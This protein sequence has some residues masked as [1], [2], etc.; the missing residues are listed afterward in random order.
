M[1]SDGYENFP[2][3]DDEESIYRWIQAVDSAFRVTQH[4]IALQPT[5]ETVAKWLDFFEN[6]FIRW[7]EDPQKHYCRLEIADINK[8]LNLVRVGLSVSRD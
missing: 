1:I 7:I 6:D 5:S 3:Q 8:A 4:T 2:S